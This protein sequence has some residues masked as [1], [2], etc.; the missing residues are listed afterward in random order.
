M[1]LV[2]YIYL[3]FL[4][5]QFIWYRVSPL[6]TRRGGREAEGNGLLNRP[7]GNNPLRGFE[8]RPLRYLVVSFESLVLS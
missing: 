5:Y 8:S 7:V 2:S 3:I 6:S 4:Q 1:Y